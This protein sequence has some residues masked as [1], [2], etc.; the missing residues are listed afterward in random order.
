[1]LC[2]SAQAGFPLSSATQLAPDVWNHVA[3]AYDGSAYSLWINGEMESQYSASIAVLSDDPLYLG[4]D[5]PVTGPSTAM[6]GMVDEIQLWEIPLKD[7]ALCTAA[8]IES[9]GVS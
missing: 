6:V 1:M 8:G 3:C 2:D 9:C 7:A 4:N 5:G